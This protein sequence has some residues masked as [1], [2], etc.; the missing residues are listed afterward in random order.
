MQGPKG[1]FP[2]FYRK[3]SGI[4]ENNFLI[5]TGFSGYKKNILGDPQWLKVYIYI[6][7]YALKPRVTLSL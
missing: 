3:I 1:N 7:I 5:G 2:N 4:F 6:Y